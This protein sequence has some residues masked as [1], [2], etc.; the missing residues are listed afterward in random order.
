LKDLSLKRKIIKERV[1]NRKA[2]MA[3]NQRLALILLLKRDLNRKF[4]E[5]IKNL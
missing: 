5:D 1:V 4:R 3:K 2:W